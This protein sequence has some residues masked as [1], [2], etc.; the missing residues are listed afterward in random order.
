MLFS[1]TLDR[2]FL[3]SLIVYHI[4]HR[5]AIGN[6]YKDHNK[7]LCRQ[8][9]LVLSLIFLFTAPG[10]CDIIDLWACFEGH[11]ETPFSGIKKIHSSVRQ[12][13]DFCIYARMMAAS[14]GESGQLFPSRPCSKG[15]GGKSTT[16]AASV[17]FGVSSTNAFLARFPYRVRNNSNLRSGF[18]H[19]SRNEASPRPC[20]GKTHGSTSCRKRH[21]RWC[22]TGS[23]RPPLP[24]GA[25]EKRSIFRD[26]RSISSQWSMMVWIISSSSG[27]AR[28]WRQ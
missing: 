9:K 2:T 25:F 16:E 7:F 13:V 1:C 11:T 4:L 17:F 27:I 28:R 18:Q 22:W 5:N 10:F 12:S 8:T 26:A 24:H 15:D 3:S 14:S 23:R 20:I 21:C 19:P 6:S